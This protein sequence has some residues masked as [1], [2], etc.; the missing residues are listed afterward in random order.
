MKTIGVLIA[1]LAAVCLPEPAHA[2]KIEVD[3]AVYTSSN[4]IDYDAIRPIGGILYGLGA[5]GEWTQYAFAMSEFGEY[6]VLM[7]CWGELNV[8]YT[9]SLTVHDGTG[10]GDQTI[11]FSFTG[12]GDCNH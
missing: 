7:K 9:L 11:Y 2:A 3:A 12:R 8:P 4:N 6:S 1:A 5:P 10:L